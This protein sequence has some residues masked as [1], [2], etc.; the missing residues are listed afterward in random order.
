MVQAEVQELDEEGSVQG[1]R[2][3]FTRNLDE[4]RLLGDWSLAPLSLL[5]PSITNKLQTE[6][7]ISTRT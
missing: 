2:T 5:R 7:A 1:N 6:K 3:G 4:V